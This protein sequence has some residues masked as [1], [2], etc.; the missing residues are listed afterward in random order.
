MR[1]HKSILLILLLLLLIDWYVFQGVQTLT[2]GWQSVFWQ[3]AVQGGYWVF[4]VGFVA[5]LIYTAFNYTV[6]GRKSAFSQSVLNAFLTITITKLVLLL[7]FFSE[8]IFR[9]SVGAFN[10]VASWAG[11]TSGAEGFIPHRSR[12]FSQIAFALAAVPF[13]SFVYGITKGKYRYVVHRHTLYFEDLPQ[14]FDGFTITQVSDIHA[15]SLEDAAAV[16][17]GIDLIK[18]QKSDLFVFTGDLVNNQAREIEPWLNHFGQ[19]KAPYGQYSIVG[20]HDYGSYI[21]WPSAEEK[22][23]NF[24][25]LKQYHAKLGYTLLL[26]ES[27]R[28]EKGGQHISLMGV[29]NWGVGFGQRGDLQKALS[30]VNPDDFKILLSHDPS[31]WDG[32]VKKH[33]AH[34][35]LTLSGHTHGMQFGIELAGFRWSPVQYRYKNWAGF[36]QEAGRFLYVNRGF[37]FH[38]FHGRIGIWPEITVLELKR[39]KKP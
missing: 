6:R 9:V 39:G 34:I 8:D 30:R 28:I 1:I 13:F 26:D 38:G 10:F 7:F 21:A 18:A 37:G 20:N 15:G 35:H 25:S 17:Q 31:H 4:I 12:L 11:G 23:R 14:N 5:I 19:I 3:Q 36:A 22:Y 2:E 32:Q 29:E 24:E 16:Q 33:P 27:V